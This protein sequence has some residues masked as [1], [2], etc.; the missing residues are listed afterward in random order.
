MIST[1]NQPCYHKGTYVT[2]RAK[3]FSL[4]INKS[5]LVASN[6]GLEY[7]D[8]FSPSESIVKDDSF[9]NIF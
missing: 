3:V 6:E 9:S 2:P 5:I 1:Y 8:L 4:E 7:E